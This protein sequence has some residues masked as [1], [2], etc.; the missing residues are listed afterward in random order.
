[1]TSEVLQFAAVLVAA[2]VAF[3]AWLAVIYLPRRTME[4]RYDP[5]DGEEKET[6][7]ETTLSESDQ[8]R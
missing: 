3:L 6:R 8:T 1:M 7:K 5:R 2:A 4:R